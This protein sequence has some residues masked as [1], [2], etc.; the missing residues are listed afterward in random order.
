MSGAF[1]TLS[2]EVVAIDG[3]TVRG[4][5]R[6]GERAIHLVPAFGSGLGV[7]Q[8][9]EIETGRGRIET[10]RCVV[11]DVIN[12]RRAASLWSGMRSIAM[13][14]AT[15]EIGDAV[16]VE[17]RYYESS[18]AVDATR[19]AHAVRSHWRSENS[20]HWVFDVA[21]GED[22]C[23]VRVEHAAQNFAILRRITMNLMRKDLQTETGLKIRRLKAAAS[24]NYRAQLLGW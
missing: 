18:L 17:R 12:V 5:H 24:D 4:S 2:V 8:G 20:M 15:R 1:P 14:E 9:Q 16:T 13:L 19:V 6:N 22:Q 21:F 23:R 11:S 7:V 10:C 3:K